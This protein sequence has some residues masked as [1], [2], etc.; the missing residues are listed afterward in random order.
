MNL[1]QTIITFVS[2]LGVFFTFP[3]ILNA[4]YID[5]NGPSQDI[6]GSCGSPRR[7]TFSASTEFLKDGRM[8]FLFL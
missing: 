1:I 3:S 7:K 5:T 2:L 8:V 6:L 4:Q